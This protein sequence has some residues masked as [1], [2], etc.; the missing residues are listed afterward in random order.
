[1]INGKTPD[2]QLLRAALFGYQHQA[3]MLAV[4]IAEIK[5][6]LSG[7]PGGRQQTVTDTGNTKRVVS[8]AGRRR[9]AE[10]QRRRWAEVHKANGT[11]ATKAPAKTKRKMSAAGRKRIAEATRKR[12][13]AYRAQKAAE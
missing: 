9:M 10:A 12:W 1:M 6:Q 7:T 3:E 11:P 8:P 4:K 5:A 13:E 2:E